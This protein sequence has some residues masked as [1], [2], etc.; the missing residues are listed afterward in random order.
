MNKPYYTA[1]YDFRLVPSAPVPPGSENRQ[2]HCA[3]LRHLHVRRDRILVRGHD[4]SRDL[5]GQIGFGDYFHL[6]LT[7]RKRRRGQ[8][9]C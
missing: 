4:L 5:I 7:G 1:K 6:L 9:R 8:R 3:A 2:G